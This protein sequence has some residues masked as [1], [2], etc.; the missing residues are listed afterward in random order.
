MAG[1]HTAAPDSQSHRDKETKR[2][3]AL[4]AIQS[5]QPV[6]GGHLRRQ[7]GNAKAISLFPDTGP[8]GLQTADGGLNILRE[9]HICD[10]TGAVDQ[11]GGQKQPV[12]LGFGGRRS[13]RTMEKRGRYGDI[14]F[15]SSSSLALGMGWAAALPASSSRMT[16]MESP[17]PFL[18]RPMAAA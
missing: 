6:T 11:S 4:S 18:S 17:A 2:R 3:A 7:A 12:G 8:Q 16:E 13:D 10:G 14:H 5:G 9:V 1:E 15:S